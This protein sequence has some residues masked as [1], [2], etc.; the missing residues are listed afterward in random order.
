MIGRLLLLAIVI[1]AVVIVAQWSLEAGD[2]R[3]PA[4]G[5]AAAGAGPYVRAAELEDFDAAGR[6]RLR[7]R[8]GRIDFDPADESVKLE[9]LALD[10]LARPGQSWQVHARHGEAPRDLSVVRLSGDVVLSGLRDREPRRATVRAETLEFDAAEQVARSDGPV[11]VEIGRHA[12]QATGMVA[13]MK[14]E[15]LRLESRVH[16][17]FYP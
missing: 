10:Y 6:L 8:A 5:T 11:R 7:V 3:R 14:R 15:T 1:G 9:T 17:R 16:G 4:A 13:N 2:A 12:L